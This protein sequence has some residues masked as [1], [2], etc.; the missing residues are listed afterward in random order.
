MDWRNLTIKQWVYTAFVLFF[1]SY[2]FSAAA[3]FYLDDFTSIVENPL[4]RNGADIDSLMR[5]YPMRFIGYA[6]F[7]LDYALF[8]V[9]PFWFRLQNY[10]IHCLL[11][12][13]ISY[14][15][16]RLSANKLAAIFAG[17][18]F[19]VHPLNTQAVVYIV[20]R[21]AELTA[22]WVVLSTLFYYLCRQNNGFKWPFA[23]LALF[24]F[25]LGI[26]TKENAV[27]TPILWYAMDR[28]VVRQNDRWR[29]DLLGILVAAVAISVVA[30][31]YWPTIDR[32]TREAEA[33]TRLD[34]FLAQ[35]PILWTYI[36]KFFI[37]INQK[38]EYGISQ[39]IFPLWLSIFAWLG[40]LCV[41]IIAFA[42]RKR[43]SMVTF[44]V[45]WYYISI[46]VESSIIP[47]SDFAFEHRTYLP[48]IGI[49]FALVPLLVGLIK[50]KRFYSLWL[51]P[52]AVI[53]LTL[54]SAHRTYLWSN[55]DLFYKN[56]YRHN[57]TNVRIQ[58][59]FAQAAY[60]EGNYQKAAQIYNSMIFDRGVTDEAAYISAIASNIKLEDWEKV[61]Q[62][63]EMAFKNIN[64]YHPSYR[65]RLYLNRGIRLK[66]Q[67][68]CVAAYE[69]FARV[70]RYFQGEF[71]SLLFRTQ[72]DVKTGN[73]ERARET[74][75]TLQQVA[76]NEPR[77]KELLNA[78][79]Q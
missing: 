64:R 53:I 60:Q 30:W 38:L 7:S 46:S 75:K 40:H 22:F 73:M 61:E 12:L 44:G 21:L 55:S 14:M 36:G 70:Q 4:L 3:P 67:D 68:N 43:W 78:M 24:F 13:T 35:G 9:E 18:I 34:Y 76:P 27:I 15:V 56:E 41:I 49:V 51:L 72:C 25:V 8:S 45:A 50:A 47:I 62:I 20:Q 57:P 48:N 16:Y 29:W 1:I 77:V 32:M 65:A 11:S 33:V 5:N 79:S 74:L 23:L 19:L 71:S 39:N 69:D 59:E 2:Y 10:I 54:T 31:V 63:E 17:I 66:E 28:F 58:S 26:F 42:V 52:V 37:P 6:S